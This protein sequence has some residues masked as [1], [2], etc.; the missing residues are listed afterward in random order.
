[1]RESFPGNI[2]ELRDRISQEELFAENNNG[3]VGLEVK[4]EE[5]R[6]LHQFADSLLL[7][8]QSRPEDAEFFASYLRDIE[9]YANGEHDEKR[10][11]LFPYWSS[12]EIMELQTLLYEKMRES[13]KN[14]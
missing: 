8:A 7:N 11:K 12:E 6:N 2:E 3:E 4:E 5:E 13:I 14:N 10:E 9:R 1:M